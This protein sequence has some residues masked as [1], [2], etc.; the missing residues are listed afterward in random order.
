M[1]VLTLVPVALLLHKVGRSS[2]PQAMP[3]MT[4]GST[5]DLSP[6][7]VQA[8]PLLTLASTLP[9]IHPPTLPQPV[10]TLS[11]LISRPIPPL[12]TPLTFIRT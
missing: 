11:P 4:P 12:T 6:L 8:L 10:L 9:D 3:Q 7:I 2:P 5:K 1:E